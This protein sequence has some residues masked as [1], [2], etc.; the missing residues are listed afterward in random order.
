M[1]AVRFRVCTIPFPF[2]IR[3]VR[4]QARPG[5]GRRGQQPP[6]AAAPTRVFMGPQQ[7][8]LLLDSISAAPSLS[9]FLPSLAHRQALPGDSP[10]SRL[11]AADQDTSSPRIP[12]HESRKLRLQCVKQLGTFI[13]HTLQRE[14]P[15]ADLAGPGMGW[16]D[17][18]RTGGCSCRHPVVYRGVQQVSAITGTQT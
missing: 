16:E 1:L 9:L 18:E 8:L 6:R 3:R 17:K 13:L 10:T 5:G 12:T 11:W 7:T 14:H 15:K 2:Q 4:I